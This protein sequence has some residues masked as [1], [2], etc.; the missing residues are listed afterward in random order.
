[1]ILNLQDSICTL[2]KDVAKIRQKRLSFGSHKTTLSGGFVAFLHIRMCVIM[3]Y[4]EE[5]KKKNREK[6]Y[7]AN[8]D[9]TAAETLL[10]RM[11]EDLNSGIG[12]AEQ[13]FNDSTDM[14]KHLQEVQTYLEAPN[15]RKVIAELQ[16]V[17][18]DSLFKKAA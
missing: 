10:Q 7:E 16:E 14:L 17:R 1:M 11:R 12:V 13:D 3:S 9:L 15:L 18:S 4:M 5:F 2:R 8:V 6:M